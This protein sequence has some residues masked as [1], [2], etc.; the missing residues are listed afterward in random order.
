MK[1]A[2]SSNLNDLNQIHHNL[3]WQIND[4]KRQSEESD[5]TKAQQQ[6]NIKTLLTDNQN[7]KNDLKTYQD[8]NQEQAKQINSIE[9]Q[10]K[11]LLSKILKEYCTDVTINGEV[12]H[13][14]PQNFD[15]SIIQS[16]IIESIITRREKLRDYV[17]LVKE[18]YKLLNN[19]E[20]DEAKI[21]KIIEYKIDPQNLQICLNII[22]VFQL[23]MQFKTIYEVFTISVSPEASRNNYKFELKTNASAIDQLFNDS[24]RTYWNIIFNKKLSEIINK[25]LKIA[26]RISDI[27]ATKMNNNQDIETKFLEWFKMK[28]QNIEFLASSIVDGDITLYENQDYAFDENWRAKL[29][30]YY[31]RI[32]DE[33]NMRLF[34]NN[35]HI[36]TTEPN[37]QKYLNII[38]QNTDKMKFFIKIEAYINKL[39]N[40][41]YEIENKYDEFNKTLIQSLEKK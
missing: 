28:E 21:N 23:A 30:K 40:A 25:N 19:N 10:S 39:F 9:F 7:L 18:L 26:V 20:F 36:I 41:N 27:D 15:F 6:K 35:N 32:I 17:K 11:E 3:E 8:I 34:F 12:I 2:I 14:D 24:D 16:A 13:F 1:L 29:I 4:L 5:K 38:K 33:K 31:N 37:M 22:N